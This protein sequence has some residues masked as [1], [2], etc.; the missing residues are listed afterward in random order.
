MPGKLPK[1]HFRHVGIHATDLD[2]LV[3]FYKNVL[4]FLESDSGMASFGNRLVFM[5]QDVEEHHQFV[6]FD[7][8]P[9][10]I[11]YNPINQLSFKLESLA[12]LKTFDGVLKEAGIEGAIATD[13]GNAWSLY[14]PDPEGNF[15]ELY[16][17][18]PF[19]TPQPCKA[20]LDLDDSEDEIL[21]TTESL[22]R[23]RPDFLTRSQW[24]ERLHERI[25]AERP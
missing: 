24:Q 7:G 3:G 17:D 2:R 5:T 10:E 9:E 1:V 16:V 4:G 13:H 22:C 11:D 23:S 25:A 18:S 19:Y 6:I 12:D 21:A 20:P 14:F 8:R 15:V